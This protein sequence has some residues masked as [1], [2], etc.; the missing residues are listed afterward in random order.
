MR[1]P[2]GRRLAGGGAGPAGSQV[3]GQAARVF[4]PNVPSGAARSQQSAVVPRQV[5]G[6]AVGHG[7]GARAAAGARRGGQRR[8]RRPPRTP[9]TRPPKTSPPAW[10]ARAALRRSCMCGTR[11]VVSA[12]C[13]RARCAGHRP[14]TGRATVCTSARA[15]RSRAQVAVRGDTAAAAVR[16]RRRPVR[17][18]R[19]APPRR[20]RCPA[21]PG[22]S[23][24]RCSRSRTRGWPRPAART[25]SRGR[26]P[27]ARRTHRGS[28][29][30]RAR[31]RAAPPQQRARATARCRA[32]QRLC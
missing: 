11:P 6:H 19:A 27:G 13:H 25:A 29:P 5:A 28:S 17:A 16:G 20:R 14:S 24:G 2:P 15:C 4:R 3:P 21:N 18:P 9:R 1:Q 22:A 12:A 32:A 10:T 8:R 26:A 23:C 7:R 30:A 31:A